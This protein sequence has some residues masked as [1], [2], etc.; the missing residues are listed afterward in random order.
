LGPTIKGANIMRVKLTYLT[1]LLAVG[2][3]AV[4]ISAAPIASA[5]SAPLQQSCTESASGSECESPGNVQLTDTPPPVS[6]E[7][8]GADGFL[9]GGYGAYG[10]HGGGI[11]GGGHR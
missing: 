1:S 4:A 3:A 2:V 10:L 8:Y 11:H 7:P 6:Y 5:A 9:I